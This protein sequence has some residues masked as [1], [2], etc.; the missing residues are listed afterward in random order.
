MM[1]YL[2]CFGAGAVVGIAIVMWLMSRDLPSEWN[3]KDH[4][5]L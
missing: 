4:F 5:D 2:L 1:D 3:D